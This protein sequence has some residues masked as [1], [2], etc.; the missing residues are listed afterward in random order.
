MTSKPDSVSTLGYHWTH[1]TG[2]TL[3]DAIN[4]WSSCGNPEISL[5]IIGR[6][7]EPQVHW[8]ATGTPLADA[9]TQ[10][11]PGGNPVLIRIIG[12]HWKTT[13]RPLEAHWKHTGYQQLFLQ[14]HPSVHWG[15]NSRHTGMTRN[16]HWLRV[17]DMHWQ[18]VF[19]FDSYKQLSI[20]LALT[21]INHELV[22]LSN[23]QF[24][25]SHV[26][27]KF[28]SKSDSTKFASQTR[29]LVS[30]VDPSSPHLPYLRMV[31]LYF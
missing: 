23:L 22:K 8:N 7:L 27:V 4:Q 31:K 24:W 5:C 15:L 10:W 2:T 14:W 11:Y 6:P 25:E 12:T 19:P 18:G 20:F 26:H 16:Y 3:T 9:S 21:K 1:Y 13:G 17:G 29:L 30:E 28:V